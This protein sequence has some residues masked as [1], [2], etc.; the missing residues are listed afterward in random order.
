[1]TSSVLEE[2]PARVA[3]MLFERGVVRFAGVGD[4]PAEGFRLKLH[5]KNPDAPLSPIY[6]NI[7]AEGHKDGTL[8]PEDFDLIAD[9]LALNVF[10][11][12]PD[13]TC[14][15]GIPVAGEPIADA[16]SPVF[17]DDELVQLHLEKDEGA[18]GRRIAGIREDAPP[19]G[20]ILLVDD[21]ITHADTKLEAIDVCE[22]AG[23]EVAAVAVLVD[24]EQGGSDEIRSKG[25]VVVAAFLL[26]EL[27]AH[28]VETGRINQ[29][30]A[31]AVEQYVSAS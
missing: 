31:D 29:A 18:D 21:L 24:R 20:Q 27:L 26:S 17:E 5:E 25:Y 6:L 10:A 7:R 16:L 8:R 22:A 1:M 13:F 19:G 11:W 9:L 30:T 23:L 4:A 14:I 3:D 2:G 28:Y 12:V 15:A